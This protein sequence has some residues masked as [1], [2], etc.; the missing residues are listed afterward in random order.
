[1]RPFLG[2]KSPLIIS[3]KTWRIGFEHLWYLRSTP[4]RGKMP[5][6]PPPENQTF[7]SNCALFFHVFQGLNQKKNITHYNGEHFFGFSVFLASIIGA[8]WPKF[9]KFSFLVS[10]KNRLFWS[11]CAL[12]FDVFQGLNQKKI[13]LHYNGEHIGFFDFF[14]LYYR[15]KL[16]QNVKNLNFRV[17]Y[18]L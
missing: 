3:Q 6:P 18:T 13:Y 5:P 14:G 16:S 9:S 2:S 10:P 8:I 15:R 1:M 11:N 7:W 4:K 17:N 12:F